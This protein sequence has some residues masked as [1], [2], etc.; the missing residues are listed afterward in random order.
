MAGGE[1]VWEDG[2]VVV[3]T[4]RGPLQQQVGG[5]GEV[6]RLGGGRVQQTQHGERALHGGGRQARTRAPE[7]LHRPPAQATTTSGQI[8]HVST[9][10]YRG[11]ARYRTFIKVSR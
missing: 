1:W 9:S 5:V 10:M 7:V 11:T 8:G 4:E 2:P 6:L 3:G